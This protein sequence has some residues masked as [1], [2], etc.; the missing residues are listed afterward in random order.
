VDGQLIFNKDAQTIQWEKLVSS[1]N[2]Y[3]K[4]THL[5]VKE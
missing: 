4:I 3:G 1:M 5:Q 2:G